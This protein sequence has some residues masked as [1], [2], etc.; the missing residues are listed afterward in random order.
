MA[1]KKR[2]Y[3]KKDCSQ[4]KYAKYIKLDEI[5]NKLNKL[6]ICDIITLKPKGIIDLNSPKEEDQSSTYT[7]NSD[8]LTFSTDNSNTQLNS[9]ENPPLD[10]SKDISNSLL[11]SEPL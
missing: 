3:Y 2:Q 11:Q 5:N 1:S 7:I 10:D 6:L 9:L 4:A 8:S